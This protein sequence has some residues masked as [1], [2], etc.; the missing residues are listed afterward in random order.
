MQIHESRPD[1]QT[2]P[3]E[4]TN[5]GGFLKWKL[6]KTKKS[7]AVLFQKKRLEHTQ[8]IGH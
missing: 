5:I 6:S 4:K 7:T 8:I 3:G 2:F 1:P